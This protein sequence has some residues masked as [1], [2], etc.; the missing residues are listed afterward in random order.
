ML[1]ETI[2][3]IVAYVAVGASMRY[4]EPQDLTGHNLHAAAQINGAGGF[5]LP[6]YRWN[7]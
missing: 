3:N 2:A 4:G 1:C 7:R 5:D 6:P